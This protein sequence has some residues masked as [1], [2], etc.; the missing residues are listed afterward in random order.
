MTAFQCCDGF[1]LIS[2]FNRATGIHVSTPILNPTP[3]HPIPLGCPRTPALTVPASGIDLAQANYLTCGNMHVS[4]SHAWPCM[5]SRKGDTDVKNRLLDPVGESEGG[6]TWEI[7]IKSLKSQTKTCCLR[8]LNWTD[9][10]PCSRFRSRIT[11]RF[12]RLEQTSGPAELRTSH[13]FLLGD[14]SYQERAAPIPEPT[15]IALDKMPFPRGTFCRQVDA[16]P[17]EPFA[18]VSL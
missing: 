18:G 15:L 13:S 12:R 2:R 9:T 10:L 4:I 17:P 7:S 16:I 11:W 1:C 14:V 5:Q 8:I 6:L 3:P